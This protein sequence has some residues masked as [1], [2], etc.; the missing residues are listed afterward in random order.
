MDDNIEQVDVYEKDV[1]PTTPIRNTEINDRPSS[2][3]RRKKKSSSRPGTGKSRKARREIE[4]ED[5]INDNPEE[6]IRASPKN[7]KKRKTKSRLEMLEEAIDV[8]EQEYVPL[9]AT[10]VEEAPVVEEP[11]VFIIIHTYCRKKK[12]NRSS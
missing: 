1:E 11:K 10:P 4:E 5:L 8:E 2:E 12:K 6:T 7:K 3:R 9:I